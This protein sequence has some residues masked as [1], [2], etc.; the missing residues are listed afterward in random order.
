MSLTIEIEPEIESRLR[1]DALARGTSVEAE[2]AR[3]LALS[4]LT[5]DEQEAWE[6]EL[7]LAAAERA[8]AEDRAHPDGR[9]TLE[10]LRRAR[11]ERAQ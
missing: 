11:T 9:K 2:A 5:A 3:R 6:D 10:D 4:T 7:D 8:R 1:A